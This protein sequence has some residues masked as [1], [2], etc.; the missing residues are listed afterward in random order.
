MPG[1]R[2]HGCLALAMV[3]ASQALTDTFLVAQQP[4]DQR[5]GI[6]ILI[7]VGDFCFLLVLRYVAVCVSDEATTTRRAYSSIQWFLYVFVLEIKLYFVCQ[8]YRNTGNDSTLARKLFTLSLS[9]CVPGI[10]VLLIAADRLDCLRQLKKEEIRSHVFIV[11]LDI[12]DILDVQAAIWEQQTEDT[13]LPPLWAENLT[14]F[15]CY[16]LLLVLPCVSLSELGSLLDR[17]TTLYPALSLI[18]I[19]IVAVF[20]RAITLILYIKANVSAVFVGKNILALGLKTCSLLEFVQQMPTADDD[21][22]ESRLEALHRRPILSRQQRSE[23]NCALPSDG[24]KH[25]K[26][27]EQAHVQQV[28]ALGPNQVH[29]EPPRHNLNQFSPESLGLLH[30]DPLGYPFGHALA[31]SSTDPLGYPLAHLISEHSSIPLA[32]AHLHPNS[33][34]KAEHRGLG[35]GLF[36]GE[37]FGRLSGFPYCPKPSTVQDRPYSISSLDQSQKPGPNS[38]DKWHSPNCESTKQH[39]GGT[40]H[41]LGS[42]GSQEQRSV[43]PE[44]ATASFVSVEDGPLS[45]QQPV[46][47]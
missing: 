7:M 11:A 25:I 4:Q 33:S 18:A 1:K 40:G 14:F 21:P 27:C 45:E 13:G 39:E 3:L 46:V 17:S 10:Y 16:I 15:Y 2:C 28:D 30:P 36:K 31:H 6:T 41:A 9:I 47:S 38:L 26:H 20:I 22:P 12:L 23:P 5:L 8:N 24:L 32:H 43:G 29:T 37:M 42:I 35:S 44:M 34:G 19:N